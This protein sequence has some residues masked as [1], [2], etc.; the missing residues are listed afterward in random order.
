MAREVGGTELPSV[1]RDLAVHLRADLALRAE[2]EARQSWVTG[3]GKLG[4]A[5]PWIVLVLLATRP[6]GGRRLRHAA[7]GLLHRGGRRRDARRVPGHGRDR[8]AARGP[9]VVPVTPSLWLALAIACGIG[10]GLGL[11]SIA[12]RLP[13]FARPRLADADRPVPARRLAGGAAPAASGA[14]ADPVP[15]LGVLAVPLLEGFQRRV[16]R[17]ARHTGRTAVRLRRAGLARGASRASGSASS[18]GPSARRGGGRRVAAL[19]G[20]AGSASRP[21]SSR[22]RS[23]G[24]GSR[25]AASRSRPHPGRAEAGGPPRERAAHRARVPRASL[26]AGEGVHDALAPRR[27][28]RQRRARRRA[29]PGRRRD[30]ASGC[31][32]P[33]ALARLGDELALPALTRCLTH[34]VARWSAVRRSPSCCACRRRTRARRRGARCSRPR[35]GRRS[36]CSCRWCS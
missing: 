12:S 18:A 9:A 24:P 7:G 26:A 15:V 2:V 25:L 13:A 30:R 1:L 33:A 21:R 20:T 8:P 27:A 31:R 4:L 11:W 6:G 10:I 5:A 36:R 17:G 16:R 23:S 34:I 29:R 3:A 35:A 22:R 19:A 32:S 14:P 28:G